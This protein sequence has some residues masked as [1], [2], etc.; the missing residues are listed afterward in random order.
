VA[1]T[2]TR[3]ASRKLRAPPRVI[4]GGGSNSYTLSI[5]ASVLAGG[6]AFVTRFG[7]PG[8]GAKPRFSMARRSWSRPANVNWS[9]AVVVRFDATTPVGRPP[10][11]VMAENDTG[12]EGDQ[13]VMISHLLYSADTAN[14]DLQN[15]VIR[16]VA[17]SLADNDKPGLIFSGIR[18]HHSGGRG[19]QDRHLYRP[20]RHGPGS[21]RRSLSLLATDAAQLGTNVQTLTFTLADWDTPKT[22]TVSGDADV[23][24]EA[25]MLSQI[26]HSITS[27]DPDGD[28]R[29]IAYG[30]DIGVQ[31][32]DAQ[33]PGVYVE[34]TGGTTEVVAGGFGDSY[35][36]S[37]TMA[38]TAD[39]KVYI[40]TD[41]QTLATNGQSRIETD[42]QGQFVRFTTTNWMT[43]VGIRLT[44]VEDPGEQPPRAELVFSRQPHDLGQ[45]LGPINIIGDSGGANRSLMAA[46][47]MPT[48][49]VRCAAQSLPTATTTARS[50][51]NSW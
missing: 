40:Q 49:R 33:S 48:G 29:N 5:P 41:G 8:I 46:V 13:T 25:R 39:V 34:E 21:G 27:N 15:L 2:A 31:I 37:L 50:A 36:M 44:A 22:I 42:G 14:A 38:P 1:R 26:S 24:R 30:G 35:K 4:E 10:I 45:I 28:Y 3:P 12:V 47:I 6:V 51:R 18:E 7:R 9:E 17:V 32:S 20:P 11:Y 16:N 23:V 19:H 43:A